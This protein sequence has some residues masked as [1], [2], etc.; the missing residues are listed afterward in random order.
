[1]FDDQGVV[2]DEGEVE[3]CLSRGV[4]LFWNSA[5]EIDTLKSVLANDH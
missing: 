2:K 3:S 4:T 1:M 5:C